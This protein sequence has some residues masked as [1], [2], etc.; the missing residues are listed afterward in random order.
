MSV[1]TIR[2]HH[3]T[4][5]EPVAVVS[6]EPAWKE[7]GTF[8]VRV[9]RGTA[10]NLSLGTIYGPVPEAE[11]EAQL[12]AV[13]SALKAEGFVAAGLGQALA[14]LGDSSPRVRARAAARLGRLRQPEAVERLLSALPKAVDEVCVI[15]DA[16]GEIGDAR[17]IPAVRPY[18]ERKLL[19]RRRSAVEALRKLGDGEGLARAEDAA[20]QR[21]PESLR[22][23]LLE[24]APLLEALLALPLKERGLALDTLYELAQ[25]A[26]SAAVRATLEQSKLG[27]PHLWRYAKSILKRA[28]LRRDHA[29]VGL[30]V[31]LVE[32]QGR[33]AAA[34]RAE[35]KSGYDGKTRETP[36]FSRRTQR[37][38][39]RAGWRYLREL[40]RYRPEEYSAAAA[41]AILSYRPED[42]EQP[43]GKYG[44]FAGCYL[45]HRVLWGEGARFELVD[46]TLRH[47]FRSASLV[48]KPEAAREEAFPELWDAYPRPFL[49]LLGAS[50][51]EQVHAFARRALG[52]PHR[53]VLTAAS[54]AELIALLDAPFEETVALGLAE[55]ERRFDPASPDWA[56]VE[57]LVDAGSEVP[58]G[59]GHRLLERTAALWTVEPERIQRFLGSPQPSTRSLASSACVAAAAGWSAELRR[60]LA[61]ELLRLLRQGEPTPEAHAGYA[62]VAVELLGRELSELTTVADLVS[63]IDTGS[64]SA[65]TVAG[66][67][68]G[69][70]PDALAELGLP[71]VLSLA[72]NELVGVRRGAQA[73]F[74][75][76]LP[77]L[78]KDPSLLLSLC[79]SDWEDN[80]AFA[81]ELLRESVDLTALGFEGLLG[82][83]DSNRVEVQ[84]LG[85]E[86]VRRHFDELQ[87]H[88]L[89]YRL[90]EHPHQNMRRF[91]LELVVLHLKE[92]FIA[93]SRVEPLFRQILLDLRPSHADKRRVIAFLTERGRRDE[94][95]ARVAA[96]ILSEVLRTTTRRDFEAILVALCEIRLSHPEALEAE[97]AAAGGA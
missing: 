24:P 34:V 28:M 33:G 47:R 72:G 2:L 93:L 62:R 81:F 49:R 9:G 50:R 17:A 58:R 43:R 37:Y 65:R 35:V 45:L 73:L 53:R 54:P 78:R 44:Q 94:Q 56:L 97:A 40:A 70:R 29:M 57:R 27:R 10:G 5:A 77:G 7:P 83:C 96:G 13:V 84:R 59:I 30:L 91:A 4:L 88:E 31:Y 87:V 42:G 20:R 14:A 86:L 3:P 22:E 75:A 79:E 38:L 95:Q 68:L 74:R 67:V 11:L 51:L 23:K 80:R 16:L 71:R 1:R 46:R 85:E 18:A 39:R 25:P 48:S 82:L 55:L 15:L 32:Q 61:V 52:G 89:I 76:A 69:L 63:L 36:I 66:H 41:E 6:A 8:L 21:L 12:A 90:A 64:P 26:A 19:S 60:T 92:G